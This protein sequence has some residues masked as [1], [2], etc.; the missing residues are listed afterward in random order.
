MSVS[1]LKTL[2]T[3]L[4]AS[5][6]LAGVS[7]SFGEELIAGLDRVPPL[8]DIVPVGGQWNENGYA[9][10]VEQDVPVWMTNERVDFY[11]YAFSSTDGATAI[12]HADAARALSNLVMQAINSQAATGLRIWPMSGEWV[13]AQ[14]E[15]SRF[16]RAYRISVNVDISMTDVLPV[17]APTPITTI[18]TPAIVGS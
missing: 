11:C 7:V 10:A 18:L 12:D 13:T 8:I 2:V 1:S 9:D 6:L 14:N 5:A 3:T 16:G 17:N 4:Q 15:I